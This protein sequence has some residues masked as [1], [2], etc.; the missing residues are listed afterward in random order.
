MLVP[1]IAGFIS[2]ASCS[3][4]STSP[5]NT[6]TVPMPTIG[7]SYIKVDNSSI[8]TFDTVK[9]TTKLDSI[10]VGGTVRM[11]VETDAANGGKD[12]ILE[13]FL[14]NADLALEGASSGW[15]PVGKYVELPFVSHTMV[16]D[17]FSNEYGGVFSH[18]S[19]VAIYNG[20]GKPFHLNGQTY[21]TDSVT[22]ASFSQGTEI[23]YYYTFIP[24]LGIMASTG[25]SGGYSDWVTSYSII[26]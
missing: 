10:H 23:D 5:S 24:T 11:V 9:A 3:S 7:S 26:P 20:A 4:S 13:S 22:V 15:G 19:V 16:T 21:P 18:D 1:A 2:L 8:T 6:N 12:T 17:T 14:T 25:N